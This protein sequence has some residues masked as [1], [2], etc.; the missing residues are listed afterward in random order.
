MMRQMQVRAL[1][2][3]GEVAAAVAAGLGTGRQHEMIDEELAVAA[4]QISEG[5]ASVRSLERVVV[6]D[7]DPGQLPPLVAQGVEL[8]G[9]GA[10]PGEQGLAGG[11]PLGARNDGMGH[12]RS[13]LSVQV[14]ARG[15]S[16]AIFS[17]GAR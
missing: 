11:E 8:V 12:G 10:L 15:R 16:A 2:M 4:E 17:Q 7:P 5:H 14:R 6:V 3:I 13:P 9:H 1:Q